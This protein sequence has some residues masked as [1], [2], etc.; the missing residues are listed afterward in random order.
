MSQV[1]VL[2]ASKILADEYTLKILAGSF[3]E[4]KS[5]QELSTKFN[6]PIAVCYR[7]IHDLETSGF[8]ECVDKILTQEGRRVKLYRSQLKGAYIF[9]EHGKLRV[10]LSLTSV[11]R[12]EFDE[13]WDALGL[14]QTADS[15]TF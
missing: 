11:P 1:N 13:T 8:L 10:H 9:F 2:D 14:V 4:P 6:I 7:K 3:K 15:G 5:V 12:I